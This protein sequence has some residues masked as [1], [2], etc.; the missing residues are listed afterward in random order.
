MECDE[1]GVLLCF[2]AVVG[3]MQSVCRKLWWDREG[4]CSTALH[5][6]VIGVAHGHLP[7]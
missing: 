5:I 4:F 6:D 3:E 2:V 7:G 1:A